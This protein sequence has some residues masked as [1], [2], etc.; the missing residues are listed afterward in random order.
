MAIELTCSVPEGSS[1]P[2][3]VASPPP[4]HASVASTVTDPGAGSASVC[5]M[6]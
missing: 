5:P 4:E 3:T 6:P 2:V 1:V